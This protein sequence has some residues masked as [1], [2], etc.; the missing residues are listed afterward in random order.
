MFCGVCT[1]EERN[2]GSLGGKA[3]YFLSTQSIGNHSFTF[4]GDRFQ[5]ERIANNHQS[6]SDYT[7]SARVTVVGQNV[8]PR[9]DSGTQLSWQPI[10]VESPG[11][12]LSSD[13][14]FIN[15]KWDLNNHWS[16]NIGV[17][18]DK[19]DGKNQA[20]ELVAKDSAISPR[21]GVIYDPTGTGDWS[22]TASYAKYVAAVANSIADS[23]SAAGNP[24]TWQYAYRGPD[25]NVGNPAN[26]TATAAALPVIML[27]AAPL[28]VGGSV[29]LQIFLPAAPGDGDAVAAARKQA[30]DLVKRAQAPKADFAAL[31]RSHSQDAS[32][33]AQ[34]GDI[35]Y[36]PLAQLTPEMRPVIE[37]LK[38]GEVAAPV[39]SAAGFHILKLVD[40]RA[41]SVAPYEQVKDELR[42]AL[43]TQRQELAAR[44][45]LEGLLNA[46]TVS[47]D[48]AALNA[49]FD[50]TAAATTA[51]PAVAARVDAKPIA[52]LR[53]E[54]HWYDK[55]GNPVAGT[56]YRH[57]R[58]LFPEEVITVV[59]KTPRSSLG[60]PY[61]P[62]SATKTPTMAKREA[63]FLNFM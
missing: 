5:E 50:Q 58:P 47:I 31:A 1:A 53:V 51:Q 48:G 44:A 54:E 62:K 19:N 12:D 32:T 26:P 17:R 29:P 39:Q 3:T 42:A 13:A 4:G 43:R 34:G 9:F 49:A 60:A 59:L 57:P 2:S 55:S 56:T 33:R 10:L 63:G 28:P 38:A 35:G 15:D 18:Y 20:G 8:F 61:L 41:A 40:L 11:T 14:L 27:L 24:Q 46:G 30:L 25:I 7:I 23:S 52:G 16:F 6:G 22:V 37:Q 21:L 36:V 45:Y